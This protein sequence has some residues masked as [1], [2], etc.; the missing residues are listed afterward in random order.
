MEVTGKNDEEL[1]VLYDCIDPEGLDAVIDRM[2]DGE[3]S[4]VYAGCRVT[5]T[6]DETICVTPVASNETPT[7]ALCDD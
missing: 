4:F 2:T 7:K 3:V 1:P 6:S 5:V